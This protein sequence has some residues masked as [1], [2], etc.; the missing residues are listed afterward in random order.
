[1]N[2]FWTLALLLAL[3]WVGCARAQGTPPAGATPVRNPSFDIWEYQVDDNTQLPVR[4]VERAVY[5]HLGPHKNIQDVERARKALEQA[6]RKAGFPTVIVN[7]PQQQV[8]GGVVHLQVTEGAVGTVEV[9]GSR[10]FSLN[11]IRTQLPA[12]AP[13]QVPQVRDVQRELTALNAQSPDRTIT[14]VLRPG[15]TPGTLDVVLKVKDQLPLHGSLQLDGR[16]TPSTSRLRLGASLRYDNLWQ[17]QHSFAMQYQ[18]APQNSDEVQVFAGTYV[19]PIGNSGDRLVLYAIRSDSNVATVG[20]LSVIGKGNIFGV[21]AVFPL[22]RALGYFQSVTLGADFKDFR[23][24]LVIAGAD[25]QNTPIHYVPL[26]V[27]YD[28]TLRTAS[29][30]TRFGIGANFGLRGLGSDQREFSDKRIFARANYFYLRGDFSRTQ[31]LPYGLRALVRLS[32]QLSDSP[33]ISNE[34]FSAGGMDSVRGYHE[35]EVLGDNGVVGSLELQSP[36]FGRWFPGGLRELRLF[37]FGD[38]AK[39]KVRQPLPAQSSEFI[40]SS[41]GLG[42]RFSGWKGLNGILSWAYPFKKAGTVQA[43]DTRV[44]FLLGYE[45]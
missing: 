7:I 8:M 26:T 36:S 19:F 14:P 27:R 10:Y 34:E 2:R 9:S 3:A 12:L 23:D 4:V 30:L 17:R 11:R 43:G 42:L 25:T 21:R 35:S 33:L 45:F 38:G 18:V 44:D 28:G 22:R 39:L 41:T 32:G 20:S 5:P 6:Y 37:A 40:L 24:S 29:A 13:G 31:A 15:A 1:M 16:N